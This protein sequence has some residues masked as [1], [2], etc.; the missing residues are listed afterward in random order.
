MGDGFRRIDLA[1]REQ[2]R[3]LLTVALPRDGDPWGVAAVLRGTEWEGLVRTVGGEAMS[4]AVHGWATPLVRELGPGPHATLRR[5]PTPCALSS[6]DQCVGATP[7]CRP[8][9]RM[10]DCYTPPDLDPDVAS[11]VTT[12]LLDLRSGRHVVVVDG[13]EFVLL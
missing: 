5:I 4:H 11:V 12:V 10:P 13:P 2:G 1:D 8:G 6:G 9:R 7:E 3:I